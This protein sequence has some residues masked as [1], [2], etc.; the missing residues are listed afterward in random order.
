[1]LTLSLSLALS[2][3]DYKIACSCHAKLYYRMKKY[4]S[5]KT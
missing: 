1:M 2:K 4:S 5:S 3:T